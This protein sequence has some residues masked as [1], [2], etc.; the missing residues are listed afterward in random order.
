MR[1]NHDAVIAAQASIADGLGVS[2]HGHPAQAARAG[3][4]RVR[5]LLGELEI[6]TGFAAL[7]V[8]GDEVEEV[9]RAAMDDPCFPTNPKAASL[10]DVVRVIRSAL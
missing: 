10:D 5:G 9:A 7:G 4:D 6:P 8:S 3:I 1:F 2:D